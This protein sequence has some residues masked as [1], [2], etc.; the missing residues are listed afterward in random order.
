MAVSPSSCLMP[1]VGL[2][3]RWA[4]ADSSGR[5]AGPAHTAELPQQTSPRSEVLPGSFGMLWQSLTPSLPGARSQKAA[6]VHQKSR[7]ADFLIIYGLNE[8]AENNQICRKGWG[9]KLFTK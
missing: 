8:V 5:W 9:E 1:S 3:H 7:R 4:R 6:S 2:S